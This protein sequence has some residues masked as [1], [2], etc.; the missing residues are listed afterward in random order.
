MI[1]IFRRKKKKDPQDFD[2]LPIKVDM[3][4]AE[5][6]RKQNMIVDQLIALNVRVMKLEGKKAKRKRG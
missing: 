5:L 4:K 6:A 2:G 3:F 1:N